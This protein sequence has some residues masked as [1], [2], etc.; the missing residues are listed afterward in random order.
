LE[1]EKRQQ[2]IDEVLVDWDLIEKQCDDFS[3]PALQ[4]KK[5][6]LLTTPDVGVSGSSTPTSHQRSLS[7]ADQQNLISLQSVDQTL[8]SASDSGS[9]V[10]IGKSKEFRLSGGS[11]AAI[12]SPD[13]TIQLFYKNPMSVE[14]QNNNR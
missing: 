6:V 2:Q 12:P 10:A 13:L 1:E 7:T 11:T 5:Q 9:N 4:K 14:V 3:S 8:A